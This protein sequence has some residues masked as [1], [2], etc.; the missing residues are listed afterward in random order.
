M[1]NFNVVSIHRH[2]EKLNSFKVQKTSYA[3]KTT[4]SSCLDVFGACCRPII[5][6]HRMHEAR[7][8]AI[9]DP[10]RLSVYRGLSLSVMGLYAASL[11]KNG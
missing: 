6:P 10:E 4:E 2:I 11:C 9:G 7:T 8:I 5:T 1:H 3:L